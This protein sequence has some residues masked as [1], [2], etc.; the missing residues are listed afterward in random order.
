MLLFLRF[1]FAWLLRTDK[2]SQHNYTISVCKTQFIYAPYL[3]N[4]LALNRITLPNAPF[5]AKKPQFFTLHF[6]YFTKKD[7][8]SASFLQL[9][10]FIQ[11]DVY[12]CSKSYKAKPSEVTEGFFVVKELFNL[13]LFGRFTFL[14]LFEFFRLLSIFRLLGR[15]DFGFVRGFFFIYDSGVAVRLYG[16]V[17]HRQ[18]NRPK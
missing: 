17:R 14:R 18:L 9:C 12:L 4:F 16:I 3:L 13:S 10:K 15:F 2:I 6:F 5:S 7:G 11:F 1:S 8:K